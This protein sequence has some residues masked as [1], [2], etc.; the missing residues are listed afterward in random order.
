MAGLSGECFVM[1]AA[2]L[3]RGRSGDGWRMVRCCC[4]VLSEVGL[5]CTD[6]GGGDRDDREDGACL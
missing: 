4:S 2:S 3:V 1:E 5:L 6:G